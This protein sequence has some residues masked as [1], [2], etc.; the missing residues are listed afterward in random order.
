MTSSLKTN[1][2]VKSGSTIRGINEKS[3]KKSD[4][5]LTFKK[6]GNDSY[7]EG[8]SLWLF[9]INNK[10]RQFLFDIVTHNFFEYFINMLIIISS[11]ELAL[12]NPLNDPNG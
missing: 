8:R 4:L 5:G 7:L 11:I 6:I 2:D 3:V 10:F 1:T 12:D 9:G